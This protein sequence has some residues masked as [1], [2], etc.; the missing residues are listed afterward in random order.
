MKPA[1]RLALCALA[2]ILL[3]APIF[4]PPLLPLCILFFCMCRLRF[5]SLE[6]QFWRFYTNQQ[7]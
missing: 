1:L 7:E 3:T 2:I 5:W 4:N 6:S